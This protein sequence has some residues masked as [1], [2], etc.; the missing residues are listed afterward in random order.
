MNGE[1][2]V[3]G[4]VFVIGAGEQV[5]SGQLSELLHVVGF[6]TRLSPFAGGSAGASREGVWQQGGAGGGFRGCQKDCTSPLGHISEQHGN[7]GKFT[8]D[9]FCR[10]FCS[11]SL[12]SVACFN[13]ILS[14]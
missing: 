5:A 2:F 13:I 14:T 9:Q 1:G 8:T 3:L 12:V 10:S 4:G 6:L 11:D 7:T